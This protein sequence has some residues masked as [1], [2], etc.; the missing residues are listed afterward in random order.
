MSLSGA[1]RRYGLKRIH[2]LH[3]STQPPKKRNA[4]KN[5]YIINTTVKTYNLLKTYTVL[6]CSTHM[7]LSP[8]ATHTD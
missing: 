5:K 8:L 1:G 6:N 2:K 4:Y 3:I 7:N